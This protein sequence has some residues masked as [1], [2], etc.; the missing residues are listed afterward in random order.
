MK[1]NETRIKYVVLDESYFNK[2]VTFITD[3]SGAFQKK[4]KKKKQLQA[5]S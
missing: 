5:I 1:Q 4:K 3:T 2:S